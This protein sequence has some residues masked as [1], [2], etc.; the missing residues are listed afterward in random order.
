M[1]G[2]QSN[3]VHFL[4]QQSGEVCSLKNHR[5]RRES[6]EEAKRWSQFVSGCNWGDRDRPQAQLET[7]FQGI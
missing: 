2:C 1:L 4:Q 5:G 6:G 7:G 3:D